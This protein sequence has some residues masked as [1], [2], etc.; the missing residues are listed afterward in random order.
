MIPISRKKT[1]IK[2][3]SLFVLLSSSLAHAQN[4]QLRSFCFDRSVNLTQARSYVK[5]ILKSSD[6]VGLRESYHCLE[7]PLE[8]ARVTLV[9][10]FLARRYPSVHLSGSTASASKI[11]CN[12]E[13]VE[14]LNKDEVTDEKGIG[15]RTV[16]KRSQSNEAQ[17]T[18]STMRLGE[19]R[20]GTLEMN[21][22]MVNI[23]CYKRASRW[24]I[25]IRVSS[26]QG[27]ISTS[28]EVQSGQQID[29]GQTV[30]DLKEKNRD[31]SIQS[32][33][34]QKDKTGQ[35]TRRYS[36]TIR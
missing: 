3:T 29:L 13:I 32:G 24:D 35:K 26:D 19:G 2:T 17:K 34:L 9:E 23:R 25:E 36:A 4:E 28:L 8:E 7:I 20:W 30:Q 21:D 27:F 22:N 33:V 1:L 6:S 18:T 10:K 14:S 15:S 5:T 31:L 11:E 16:L 12:I